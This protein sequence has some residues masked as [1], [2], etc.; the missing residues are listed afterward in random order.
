MNSIMVSVYCATYNHEKYIC[1]ALDSILMQKTSFPVE[2]LVGEDCSTDNTRAVL[3]EYEEQHPGK[4]TV[5]YRDHNMNA[6]T[7]K[8]ARDL[9]LR[10]KGKYVIPLEG[11]DFWIDEMKLQKQVDFLENH[12]D[13][14]AVAHNCLVVGEDSQPTGEEFPECKQELYTFKHYATGIMPGQT[15]TVMTRN[16]YKENIM[17]TSFVDLTLMPGDRR[18]FFSL[19]A[20][21]K[22]YCMQETMSAYRHIISG[23]SSYSANLKRNFDRTLRW[24]TAQLEYAEK[25]GNSDALECAELL[26]LLTIRDG[27][28]RK[29]LSIKAGLSQMKIVRHRIRTLGLMCKRDFNRF[30]LKKELDI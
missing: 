13:Y 4:L 1:K 18:L 25:T 5:F 12:P 15:T 2:I 14:I 27:M 6:E 26:F 24:H 29:E 23:G 30:V 21:G 8:N 22:I 9:K 7:I 10:C 11:D 17:D 16:Y 28:R 3:K 19:L 20:N